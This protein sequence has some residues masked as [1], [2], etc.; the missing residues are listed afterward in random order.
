LQSDIG[1]PV[2]ADVSTIS[3]GE[4]S[5]GISVHEFNGIFVVFTFGITVPRGWVPI[6]DKDNVKGPLIKK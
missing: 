1:S 2:A 6:S 3:I 5:I 4:E